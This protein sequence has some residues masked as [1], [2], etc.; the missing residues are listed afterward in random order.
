VSDGYL[1]DYFL[2][3][4]PWL[5]DPAISEIAINPD[6]RVWI[7]REGMEF[8]EHVEPPEPVE[9]DRIARA[10]AGEADLTI[11]EKKPILS[12]QADW[13]NMPLRIQAVLPPA[14]ERGCAVSIRRYR[15][16]SRTLEDFPFLHGRSVD[17]GERHADH[18]AQIQR[19]IDAGD[20]K[21][22]LQAAVRLK[23]NVLIS[24][25]TS[26]AKTTLA[27]AMIACMAP[28]E[29]LITIEDARELHPKHENTV[30]L[31]AE[32]NDE[33]PRSATKLLQSALR[34]RPDRIVVGELR[35]SE[36]WTFLEAINTGHGGSIST[37]HAEHPEMAIERLAMMVTGMGIGMP[38]AAI[39]A[40]VRASIGL[41]VQ[42]ERSGGRRG[43]A[44]IVVPRKD[45]SHGT[46]QMA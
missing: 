40:Y 38:H 46:Q 32:R 44:S 11:S 14:I 21:A 4:A 37:I 25:G 2:P 43:I 28:A 3:I 42:L 13:M 45:L 15:Q 17:A 26:T 16:D 33:S 18:I 30:E 1:H 41:I 22:A 34:M 35:G 29:R 31:I 23:L 9:A 20:P 8:L 36:A 10:V 24:G 6:G 7:E 12:A 27:R 19:A 39:L 5:E